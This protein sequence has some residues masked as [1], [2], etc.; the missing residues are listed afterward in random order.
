MNKEKILK[1]EGKID[2]DYL[3]DILFVKMKNREYSHSIE[4]LNYV[5]DIDEEG[6]IIG[7]QIFDASR[8][9]NITKE[10]LRMVK[11]WKL[12]TKI[13]NK[14]IEVNFIFATFFRNKIIEK[15]PILVQKIDENLPNSKVVC[16]I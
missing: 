9:F 3:N 14:I 13:K 12:E 2:Y 8:L 5:I 15:N 7:L 4:L 11:N 1:A 16:T 6:F 10:S